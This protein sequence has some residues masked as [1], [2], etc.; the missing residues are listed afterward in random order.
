M[1]HPSPKSV[2]AVWLVAVPLWAGAEVAPTDSPS[3]DAARRP[4]DLLSLE[5]CRAEFRWLDGHWRRLDLRAAPVHTDGWT[6]NIAQAEWP[7]MGLSY[8]GYA[9][10]ELAKSDSDRRERYLDALRWVLNALQSPRVAGFVTPHFGDPFGPDPKPAVFLHGHFLNVAMRYR[11]VSG[12]RAFDTQTHRVARSLAGGF[13]RSGQ[14][15]L[16]S[17]PD[18]WWLTDN[19]PAL[20]GLAAY[21]RAFGTRLAV[22]GERFVAAVRENYLDR[23]TG[24]FCTYVLPAERRPLQGPRGISQM[25]GLHFLNEIDPDFAGE[26]YALAKRHLFSRVLGIP[27]FRE[28]PAG[29]TVAPDVDSGPLVFGLGPSASGFAVAAAATMGDEALARDL[30][31]AAGAVGIPVFTEDTLTYALMPAVGQSVILYGKTL[32]LST[33][34]RAPAHAGTTQLPAHPPPATAAPVNAAVPRTPSPAPSLLSLEACRAE[35]RWLRR[36]WRQLDLGA[37]PVHTDGWTTNLTDT[38]WVVMGL[39]YHAYAAGRL[40]EVDAGQRADYVAEMRWVGEA[41]QTPRVSGFMT[42]HFGNAFGPGAL[43]PSVFLH[44]HWLQVMLRYREASGDELF[45]P[46]LQRVARSLAA[47]FRSSAQGILPS[48][49]DM[50]WLTDNFPALSALA[51]Y[52]RVFGTRLGTVADR[53]LASVRRHYL[54]PRTGM[55]A[56]FVDPAAAAQL[57]GPRGVSQMYGLHFLRDFAPGLAEEQYTLAK[58]HLVTR[59]LGVPG[60]REFPAGAEVMPDIASGPL[61]LGLGPSA[62]GFA[63][64]AAAVMDDPELA[65]DLA[66]A[67]GAV[68]IPVF[69]DGTLTYALMPAVGQSVILYGKTLLLTKPEPAGR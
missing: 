28:F 59:L 56:T 53:T 52:D 39:S 7:V 45:D 17:Y 44:G 41:M 32:L 67:A 26:Q 9:A 63:V 1:R 46:L 22:V 24:M 16:P 47:A 54:D 4:P 6:T 35:F 50:W 65:R 43:R 36:H 49:R 27:G 40:A 3:G 10:A 23:R 51:R 13:A 20:A 29:T 25:Y 66:R 12:D 31:R 14:P 34:A 15:V 38:E 5:A 57:Q 2:L 8:H 62:S 30:A 68:G 11:G 48:Y 60:V 55:L 37:A 21:D 42:A 33:E 64:A 69:A 18:M 61:V 19:F 58:R